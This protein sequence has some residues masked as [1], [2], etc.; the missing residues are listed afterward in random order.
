MTL[1]ELELEK[2][3]EQR[4]DLIDAANVVVG[5]WISAQPTHILG[6]TILQLEKVIH[7]ISEEVNHGQG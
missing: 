6:S 4:Q 3:T 1:D 5:A 2:V 7:R